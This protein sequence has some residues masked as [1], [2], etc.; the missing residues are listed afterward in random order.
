MP[1]HRRPSFTLDQLHTFLAVAEREHLTDA[2]TR[3]GLSQGSVSAQVHR[4]E[5]ALGVPLLHRVGR[6]VR[7][8]DVGRGV[9]QLGRRVLEVAD[10]VER[11]ASGYLAF[12]A[13]E[14]SV[15]AGH[16]IGAHRLSGWLAP[17]VEAHP[18]VDIAIR[19]AS[20]QT[21]TSL[22]HGGEVDIVF[23]GSEVHAT[24]VETIVLERTRLVAV[25]AAQHPL[26]ASPRAAMN[27]GRHRLLAHER[28][29]ATRAHA[30]RMLRDLADEA[31]TVELEEGAL[32]AAL[33]AGLGFAVMPQSVVQS[34]I[35][36]GRLVVLPLPGRPVSQL[37]LAASR[38]GLRTPATQALWEHLRTRAAS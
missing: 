17:F 1:G 28:G 24:G 34:D 13:G 11:L 3:L 19:L 32:M 29:S 30:D 14:I 6:N 31:R 4:L 20:V 26:A 36:A 10:E 18:M 21:M 12:D 37:Y 23:L 9:R 5:R 15:G 16:V 7:L 2:A 25:A 33:F 8:T 27:L 22:L 38:A 35:D